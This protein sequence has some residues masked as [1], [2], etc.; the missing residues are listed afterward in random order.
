MSKFFFVISLLF[1]FLT[2][3]AKDSVDEVEILAKRGNGVVTQ[4]AFAARTEKIPAHSRLAT[5]RDG[6]R[7]QDLINTILLRSQLAH[8]ASE[9]GYDK[10]PT[11][12]ARMKLAAEAELAEAWAQHYVTMQPAADYE[13]LAH[14]YYLLHQDEIMT[15]PKIDVSHILISIEKHSDEEAQALVD[16]VSQQLKSNPKSFDELVLAYSEDPSASSNKGKF[17]NVK[18]GDMVK[19]FEETA[20]ALNEGQI[21]E[22]VRTKYGYHI[23]RLDAKIAPEQMSF[24]EVKTQLIERERK[25]HEDRI[26]QDYIGGLTS[27]AVEMTEEALEQMVETQF[28]E[29]YVDPQDNDQ[30]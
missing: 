22:P 21:S 18:K 14:E 6:K 11:V 26:M 16:S 7:L 13:A 4:A 1:L 19:A 12:M 9:A 5:L 23:I 25:K 27:I 30:E 8:D 20:F 2:A 3:Q 29:D 28:G 15:S 24:G 17:N 10:D